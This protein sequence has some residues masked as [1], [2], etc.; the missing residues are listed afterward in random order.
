MRISKFQGRMIGSAL[1]LAGLALAAAAQ[2]HDLRMSGAWRLSQPPQPPLRTADG[3]EPPLTEDGRRLLDERLAEQA[4]G[5]STDGVETACLPPGVPRLMTTEPPFIIVQTPVKVTFL[6]EYQHTIRHIHLN[7]DHPSD[8]EIDPFFGGTSVGHWEGDVL[9]VRTRR[10]NDQIRL[11]AAGTPQSADSQITERFRVLDDGAR[12]ENIVTVE[13]P[14]NYASAWSTRLVYDRSDQTA[15]KED[16]CAY[17][18]LHPN[19]RERIN[20]GPAGAPAS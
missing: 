6:H 16:V 19:L 8:D 3:Q 4:A 18:L 11:D 12:L 20:A 15:L 17:K 13:D 10:F 7:E 14:A 2:A 9:V 5:R 1:A